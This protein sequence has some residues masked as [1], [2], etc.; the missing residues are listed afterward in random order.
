MNEN[1]LVASS[2]PLNTDARVKNKEEFSA[3]VDQAGTIGSILSL[4]IIY[5]L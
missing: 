3:V 1:D 4:E 2:K 5:P